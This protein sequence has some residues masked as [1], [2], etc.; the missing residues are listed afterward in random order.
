MGLTI[1]YGLTSKT[2]SRGRAKALVE[3]MRQLALDLPFES[4]DDQGSASRPRR[5]PAAPRR[6]APRRDAVL[7]R[8]GRLQARQTSPGIAS[9]RPASPSSRLEI[10]SFWTVP[11]PGSEWASFGLAR[12][13]AEIEVTYCPRDDD[14]FIKTIKKGGSTR[15][16][17][18]W[19]RWERWLQAN[20][21]SR[22]EFPDDEKFQEK[23]KVKTGLGS[24]WRYSTLLQDP[25]CQRHQCG[26][27]PNFVRCHLCVIHLLDRIAQLPT[28]KV[29]IER[30]RQVRAVLLH[31]R[32]VG[33]RA[34]LH[35]ARRQVRREGPGGRSR[36]VERDD[37]R[38]VRGA[39]T[40]CSRRADPSIG[41]ESPIIGV[42]RLRASGV[43]GATEP[44][45][46]RPVP[47]GDEETGRRTTGE[48]CCRQ[49][50]RS[51]YKESRGSD[52]P[53][54]TNGQTRRFG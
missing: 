33:G 47:G 19:E 17:F 7:C 20:G 6:P 26:G 4:V 45:V 3:Q 10:F 14:R 37:R 44:P 50:I 42:P 46:P 11:G 51:P 22:W 24:G 13:P 32:P 53:E 9:N 5:V 35:L 2:R 41:V 30:R 34:G 52:G 28:M 21:H 54:V 39:S 16:Q 15:W 40:T 36:G 43:Q 38:H 23:R 25:V 8:P 49:R 18:D 31:G 27:I 48:G 1:H 29:E 12:Y